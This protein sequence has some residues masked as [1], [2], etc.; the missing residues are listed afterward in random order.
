MK[1]KNCGDE[2]VFVDNVLKCQSCGA[3]EESDDKESKKLGKEEQYIKNAVSLCYSKDYSSAKNIVNKVLLNNPNC[4]EAK[5]LSRLIELRRKPS[6]RFQRDNNQ[7]SFYD[8]DNLIISLIDTGEIEQIPNVIEYL[9]SEMYN[10]PFDRKFNYNAILK[11]VKDKNGPI[12][13][14]IKGPCK[15][16]RK[17][18]IKIYIFLAIIFVTA[19][20]LGVKFYLLVHGNNWIFKRCC[21]TIKVLCL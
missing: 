1:C 20:F 18:A 17:T 9:V 21:R 10:M 15:Q 12:Y 14:K 13:S 11:R 4:L 3:V 7:A 16:M 5:V 19:I 2:L 6:G 8:F